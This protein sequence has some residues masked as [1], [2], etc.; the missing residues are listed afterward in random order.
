MNDLAE[1]LRENPELFAYI[2]ADRIKEL[3]QRM[4]EK[5]FLPVLRAQ[6]EI[7]EEQRKR[8]EELEHRM[9]EK[10]FLI[11]KKYPVINAQSEIIEEQKQR[12]KE[13]EDIAVLKAKQEGRNILEGY[14]LLEL[15]DDDE[16]AEK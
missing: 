16:E 8:I 5:D 14:V 2:A 15:Y 9:H 7:I 11:E 1:R 4:S 6:A 3:E 10:D 13:L 12:I